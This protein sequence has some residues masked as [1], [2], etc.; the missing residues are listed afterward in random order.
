MALFVSTWIAGTAGSLG[1]ETR[2]QKVRN[3]KLK[4]ESIGRWLYNDLEKVSK[5]L[6]KRI[7]R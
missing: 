4:F 1:A 3:D 5:S 6:R 2:E 7:S